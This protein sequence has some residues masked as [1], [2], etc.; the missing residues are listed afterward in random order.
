MLDK[1]RHCEYKNNYRELLFRLWNQFF[2]QTDWNERVQYNPEIL[3]TGFCGESWN[4]LGEVCS[5]ERYEWSEIAHT[6]LWINPNYIGRYG[7]KFYRHRRVR[8]NHPA[9]LDHHS[10]CNGL[11]QQPANLLQ[12][13]YQVEGSTC[14]PSLHLLLDFPTRLDKGNRLHY[15]KWYFIPGE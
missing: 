2:F 11:L 4:F 10:I 8:Y 5:S 7:V 12:H 1:L 3:K 6:I 15:T 13:R 9:R 14:F